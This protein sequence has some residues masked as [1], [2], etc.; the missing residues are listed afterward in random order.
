[1]N[2]FS[3]SSNLDS[4]STLALRSK[5]VHEQA[6]CRLYVCSLF[7]VSQILDSMAFS[8]AEMPLALLVI[9]FLPQQRSE[10]SVS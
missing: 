2:Y 4:R 10:L 9:I 1:M 3:V 5:S 6:C 7:L 8:L